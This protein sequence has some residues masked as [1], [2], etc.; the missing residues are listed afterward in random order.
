M[1]G[2]TQLFLFYMKLLPLLPFA[3]L[4]PGCQCIAPPAGDRTPPVITLSVIFDGPSGQERTVTVT[5][6]G[7]G[8][9]EA[10][11][12]RGRSVTVLVAGND[13][14]GIRTLSRVGT[15][16]SPGA[17]GTESNSSSATA[18][19]DFSRCAKT[20]RA[21]SI[22]VPWQ[23]GIRYDFTAGGSDF[24]GNRAATTPAITV[25]WLP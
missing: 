25:R 18:P 24:S 22:D 21:E 23:P 11:I 13:T 3:L 6:A 2:C 15:S 7:G 9:V 5:S 8:G 12:P 19:F 17:D 16:W 1:K 14:G 10:E 20:Y 4:L